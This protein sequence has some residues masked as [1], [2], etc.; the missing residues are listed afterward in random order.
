MARPK[1]TIKD[2]PKNWKGLILKEVE[3]GVGFGYKSE[4]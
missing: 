1:K 3:A 4:R 2:L